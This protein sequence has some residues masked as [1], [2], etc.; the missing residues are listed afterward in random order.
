MNSRLRASG[1]LPDSKQRSSPWRLLMLLLIL[2]L[3]ICAWRIADEFPGNVREYRLYLL[4][5]RKPIDFRYEELSAAW[6]EADLK[7]RFPR[8]TFDCFD[9]RP[10]EY[11]DERSC[12]TDIGAHNDQAAM[13]AAFYFAGGGL[14]HAAISM[15]SWK[16][17]ANLKAIKAAYGRPLGLFRTEGSPDLY[18]WQLDTGAA[19][20]YGGQRPLNPVQFV[21][22]LWVNER[23]CARGGCFTPDRTAVQ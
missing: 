5:D 7:A 16:Y 11:L 9:N 20:F 12:F 8:H 14:R 2:F 17:A 3:A 19:L 1:N 10:G 18:G 23:D 6:T 15:P 21:T 13:F 4:E 22:L